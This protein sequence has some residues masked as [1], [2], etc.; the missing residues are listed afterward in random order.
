MEEVITSP[1][2]SLLDFELWTKFREVTNE[3]IVT[4]SGR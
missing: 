3:M 2:V 1:H 4:K